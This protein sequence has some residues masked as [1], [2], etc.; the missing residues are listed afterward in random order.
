MPGLILLI[1]V[2]A[3]FCLTLSHTDADGTVRTGLQGLAVYNKT[4]LSGIDRKT[5]PGDPSGCDEPALL[6]FECID[7]DH[8]HVW[9]LCEK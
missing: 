3:V 6:F 5:I 7:G 1:V 2:I 8:D 9:F 4:R